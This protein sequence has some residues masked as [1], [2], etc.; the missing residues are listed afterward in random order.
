M[1]S[2]NWGIETSFS[3]QR[4]YASAA[5]SNLESIQALSSGKKSPQSDIASFSVAS[6][7]QYARAASYATA[8]NLAISISVLQIADGG[9]SQIQDALIHLRSLATRANSSA[10]SDNDRQAIQLEINSTVDTIDGLAHQTR[11]GAT[12]LLASDSKDGS[13]E[14]QLQ[15]TNDG[16]QEGRTRV[17]LAHL[18]REALFGDAGLNITD[19]S[20]SAAVLNAVD[21][22]LNK[23]GQSRAVIGASLAQMNIRGKT[24]DTELLQ[25]GTSIAELSD[26]DIAQYSTTLALSSLKM[27]ISISLMAQTNALSSDVIQKLL[28]N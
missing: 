14:T 28:R 25:M 9:V 19:Q 23:V 1:F 7:Q 3:A 26:A 17:T 12:S 27:Q 22:A 8:K 6:A 24:L 4:N 10:L 16:T 21:S 15:I 20:S 18:T 13:T 2:V 11:F 5:Q